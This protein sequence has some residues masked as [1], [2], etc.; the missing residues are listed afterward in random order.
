MGDLDHK[1]LYIDIS[2]GARCLKFSHSPHLNPYSVYAS[3]AGSGMSVHMKLKLYSS[4]R[5]LRKKLPFAPRGT[6][7][8]AYKLLYNP[9][10]SMQRLFGKYSKTQIQQLDKSQRTAAHWTCRRWRNTSSVGEMLDELQWPNLET[11]RDHSYLFLFHKIH[12][13]TMSIGK[14]R[15]LNPSHGSRLTRSPLNFRICRPQVYSDA[16]TFFP[17]DYSHLQ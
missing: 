8:V 10:W 4:L 17:H 5:F 9:N 2:S 13:G 12:C 14:N 6:K 15:Y 16:L 1:H 11:Q 3:N 7:E